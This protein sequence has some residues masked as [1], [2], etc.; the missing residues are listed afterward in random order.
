MLV[1]LI[2]R[3]MYDRFD[4][5]AIIKSEKKIYSVINLFRKFSDENFHRVFLDK[6]LKDGDP[7]NYRADGKNIILIQSTGVLD[8]NKKV[9]FE[10]DVIEVFDEPNN[11]KKRYVVIW[12]D[13]GAKFLLRNQNEYKNFHGCLD[14]KII[15]NFEL[16]PN[17]LKNET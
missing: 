11:T 6:H 7:T 13:V 1:L 5:R 9:I 16:N 3:F 17:L 4:Y 10:K 12:D 15:G 14:M 2:R 8:N